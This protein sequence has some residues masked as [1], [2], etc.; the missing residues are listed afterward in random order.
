MN[1][2][3]LIKHRHQLIFCVLTAIVVLS[4]VA[5]FLLRFDFVVPAIEGKHLLWAI[6]VAFFAK[7]PVF[8]AALLHRGWWSDLGIPD[9]KRIAVANGIASVLSSIGIFFS[10]GLSFPRSI[11]ILDPLIAFLA[12]CA[13]RLVVHIIQVRQKNSGKETLLKNVLIYGA[14]TTAA[15]LIR[16][17]GANPK[18]DFQ[19]LGLIDDDARKQKE[20]LL[21][22]RVLGKGEDLARIVEEFSRHHTRISQVLITMPSASG[23]QMQRV[24][25]HCRDAGLSCK[26]LPAIGD[27]LTGKGLTTQ[28]RDIALEDLLGREPVEL[29]EAGIRALITSSR[30]LVTGAAGSIGS[31]LCRQIAGY[32]PRKLVLFDQAESDLFRIDLEVRDKFPY[33]E[34]VSEIGDIRDAERVRE[35]M[36]RYKIDS[37]FHAAAY[38]HVPLMED[39]VIEAVRNNVIGTWNVAKAALDNRVK[40]F[41]MI[42]SDKA[43]N[44]TNVMGATKR[45][46]ELV[47]A[48]L[49]G[50]GHTQFVSVRFGNVLGSNGSVV[51]IFQSQIASRG[52]ITVTHPEV[53]RFFMTIRESVQLVLQASTMGNGSEIFVLDMGEPVKIVDLARNMIRFAGLEPDKDIQIK[54]VGLR[55]GEKLFEELITE[56]E[57]IR[58]THHKKIKI[59]QGAPVDCESINNWIEQLRLIVRSRDEDAAIAHLADLLPEYVVSDRWS[60]VLQRRK[61]ANP[62]LGRGKSIVFKRAT[63]SL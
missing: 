36:H 15:S 27:L 48:S 19:I 11:Y 52:P 22:L 25:A 46:A 43:V 54:F 39:H 13:I 14:G 26:T 58:P 21:G 3:L 35:L 30:V 55:P 34:M 38:K 33:A 4:P 7:M 50:G 24:I 9:V 47:V 20:T 29:D 32:G 57:N 37:V 40:S 23:K 31:E 63:A 18:L 12:M 49:A 59:F 8:Y 17:I 1:D 60:H 16:E 41:V 42:S 2:V 44:P 53:R 5:A 45:A 28:F 10:C 6:A 56:G 61:S 62:Q 51:P